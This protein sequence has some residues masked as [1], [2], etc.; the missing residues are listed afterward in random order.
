M[1]L[2]L[3]HIFL[4]LFDVAVGVDVIVGSIFH[5]LPEG[6]AQQIK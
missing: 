2:Y 4:I 5:V 3:P 6:L 1:T